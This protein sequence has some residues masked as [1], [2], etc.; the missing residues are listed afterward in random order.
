M[1][2]FRFHEDYKSGWQSFTLSIISFISFVL[3]N[4]IGFLLSY[5]GLFQIIFGI[6]GVVFLKF[7]EGGWFFQVTDPR[8][9][10]AVRKLPTVIKI[11]LLFRF[12]GIFELLFSSFFNYQTASECRGHHIH[13]QDY[14]YINNKIEKYI[15]AN[16]FQ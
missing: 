7:G 3:M 15:D 10:E 1:K 8:P 13:A 4:Y 14:L 6:F 5:T 9:N 2:T 11:F 12:K 16:C